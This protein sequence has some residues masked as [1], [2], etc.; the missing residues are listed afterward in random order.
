MVNV[1][2]RIYV[3]G[4]G[5]GSQLKTECRKAFKLFFQ[6]AGLRN[7]LTIVA[8]GPRATAYRD[9]RIALRNATSNE[10]PLLLVD[11]ETP[12][13]VTDPWRHLKE[14]EG[15]QWDKP[16]KASDKHA[17]LMVECMESWFLADPEAMARFF[18]PGF[19][20]NK[21]PKN[22]NIEKVAK[23]AVYDTLKAATKNTKSNAY[24]KGKHSFQLLAQINPKLVELASPSAKRLL[25]TLRDPKAQ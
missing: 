6:K 20:A 16:D 5:E 18:G 23:Q 15:D 13:T 2:V 9:F 4:G 3:E 19:N 17:H 7:D 1:K 11:S 24:S 14:R 25:D 21:L 10:L 12:V 8:C 22:P